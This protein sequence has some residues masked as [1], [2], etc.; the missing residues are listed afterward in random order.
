M[1][2]NYENPESPIDFFT[3]TIK[4]F[5][6]VWASYSVLHANKKIVGSVLIDFM[7]DLGPPL[8]VAEDISRIEVAKMITSLSIP[9]DNQG[10]IY[11]HDV[12]FSLYK[13]IYGRFRLKR[14]DR[15]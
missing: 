2:E 13:N 5:K 12:L 7:Y 3:R 6:E 1:D 8:G 4:S 9:G 11:Y 10:F 14:T 15:N